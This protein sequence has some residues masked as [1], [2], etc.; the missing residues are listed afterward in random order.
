M[1]SIFKKELRDCIKWVPAGMLIALVMIWQSLPIRIEQMFGTEAYLMAAIG[2]SAAL[3]AFAFGLLQS[4]F[5]IRNDAR[6]YLLHL[7]RP[8]VRYFLGQ[9]CFGF[10]GVCFVTDAGGAGGSVLSEL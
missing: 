9:S 8:T 5:D 7:S 3:I 4:L 6:G 2:W 10:R 1:I